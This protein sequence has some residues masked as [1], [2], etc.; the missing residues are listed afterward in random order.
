MTKASVI[1]ATPDRS[2]IKYSINQTSAVLDGVI[3]FV[4]TAL[5]FHFDRIKYTLITD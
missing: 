5:G 4:F 3:S 1:V 2:N